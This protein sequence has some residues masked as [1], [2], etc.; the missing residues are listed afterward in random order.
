MANK[1]LYVE[2]YLS[3]TPFDGLMAFDNGDDNK[4][5]FT[6]TEEIVREWYAMHEEEFIEEQMDELDISEEECSFENWFYRTYVMDDF[7]GFYDFIMDRSQEVTEVCP[8]CDTENNYT[9]YECNGYVA[10]CKECGR[11]IM[12][13]SEC[14]MADDNECGKCDWHEETIDGK[15]YGVCFRGRT[16]E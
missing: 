1:L 9:A 10:T 12:L 3:E 6:C 16:E 2:M 11:K 15:T 8:H 13:C 5:G 7:D 4:F 14:M